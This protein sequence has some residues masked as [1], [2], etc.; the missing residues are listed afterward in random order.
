MRPGCT[1]C[2]PRH[3]GDEVRY[4]F[5]L[6]LAGCAIQQPVREVKIPV[7]VSCIKEIPAKPDF[8][9]DMQL[10][11]MTNYQF[12]TALHADRLLRR[13]YESMLEAVISACQ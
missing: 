2:D 6:L 4:A 13:D 11:S 1:G 5:L 10:M 8:V 12:V 9:T 7:P 3:K